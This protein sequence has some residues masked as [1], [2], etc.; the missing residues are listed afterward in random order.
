MTWFVRFPDDR[1]VVPCFA[2]YNES[3]RS[4]T[5]VLGV[6]V[7]GLARRMSCGFHTLGRRLA[8][9]RSHRA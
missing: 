1:G 6:T 9:R 5:K 7:A 2:G 8:G 4:R 3:N